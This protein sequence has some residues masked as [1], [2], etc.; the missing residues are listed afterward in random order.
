MIAHGSRGNAFQS[1]IIYIRAMA[2]VRL[3]QALTHP[4]SRVWRALTDPGLLSA[5]FMPTD[6]PPMG[7]SSFTIFA[8]TF[9][10]FLGPV[11]GEVREA[12]APE[13]LV[14]VWE[15]EKLHTRV[16]WELTPTESG[17]Q[18]Q[19]TQS[20]FL[21]A[22][23]RLRA[24]AL[25]AT[26]RE[27][28][29]ERLPALLDRL[30]ARERRRPRPAPLRPPYRNTAI[31]VWS[32]GRRLGPTP[33]PARATPPPGV[34]MVRPA[35]PVR[36]LVE[37]P[38]KP[39]T[40][41]TRPGQARTTR[42]A[43]AGADGRWGQLLSTT[44]AAALVVTVVL[45]A[46]AYHPAVPPT[47]SA[48]GNYRSG[49][50]MAVQPPS[51]TPGPIG[52]I[53]PPDP[54]TPYPSDGAGWEEPAGWL[55]PPAGGGAPARG[56]AAS[57]GGRPSSETSRPPAGTGRL[58]DERKPPESTPAPAPSASFTPPT[59]APPPSSAPP[60]EPEPE[61]VP[62]TADLTS[63]GLPL[64][65]GRSVTVRV[66]NPGPVPVETW[67][68]TMDVGNQPVVDVTGAQYRRDGSRVI[69]TPIRPLGPGEIQEIRFRL[70]APLLGLLGASN[71]SACTIDGRPCR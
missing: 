28:F 53:T 39:P 36:A 46:V 4:C 25:L 35:V 15:G 64:L 11:T 71:P 20:G 24:E 56:G 18:L 14:M 37:P 54:G 58:G 33:A 9:P 66:S 22:P 32:R 68:V 52:T 48:G 42:V 17:C 70:Q 27:L 65:G 40:R 62:L 50:A 67:E 13:R 63:T 38:G 30:A 12:K 69:L 43:R 21:G 34:G 8:G 60:P 31:G 29:G 49:P 5:W 47:G 57:G 61:P 3:E 19:V 59:S 2:E 7:G 1:G 16:V 23:A 51:I 6:S 44:S 10:G 55:P 41:R 26:Y 45:A